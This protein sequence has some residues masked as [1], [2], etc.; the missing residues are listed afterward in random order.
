MKIIKIITLLSVIFLYSGCNNFTNENENN[1]DN[2][3]NKKQKTI[4]LKKEITGFIGINRI[5]N[6]TVYADYN[7]NNILDR[8]EPSTTSDINGKYKLTV[9]NK[10]KN[11]NI[12][13][14]EGIEILTSEI[15]NIDLKVYIDKLAKNNKIDINLFTTFISIKRKKGENK[16]DSIK[17]I[18]KQLEIPFNEYNNI[19]YN[20]DGRLSNII[21]LR[22]I[23]ILFENNKNIIIKDIIEKNLFTITYN[24][25]IEHMVNMLNVKENNKNI[26]TLLLNDI[27]KL[28]KRGNFI[29]T[30][31]SINLQLKLINK[32]KDSEIIVYKIIKNKLLKIATETSQVINVEDKIVMS[33][34]N[35]LNVFGNDYVYIKNNYPIL[36]EVKIDK[37]DIDLYVKLISKKNINKDIDKYI[38]NKYKIYLSK[39]NKS[40]KNYI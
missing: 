5:N 13:A 18:M 32:V 8:D 26:I 39:I 16:L 22:N 37:I 19:L 31:K 11:Y 1:K 24:E 4:S 6:A 25:V 20:K 17:S 3:E 30:Q 38:Q 7:D 23:L 34:L 15:N 21:M 29:Y 35:V 12:I 2:K 10:Y 27:F 9:I 28:N 33:I 36:F 14:K 40:F